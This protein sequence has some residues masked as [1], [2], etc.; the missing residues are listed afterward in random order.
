MNRRNL[1]VHNGSLEN[2]GRVLRS[3]DLLSAVYSSDD[4]IVVCKS[5]KG[6][7]GSFTVCEVDS[8]LCNIPLIGNFIWSLFAAVA[9]RGRYN[10]VYIHDYLSLIFMIFIGVFVKAKVKIYDAHE[11]ILKDESG[12]SNYKGYWRNLE[13]RY[14]EDFNCVICANAERALYVEDYY[15]LKVIPIVIP[16]FLEAFV[17]NTTAPHVSV[18]PVF[19]YQGAL[20][21]DRELHRFFD[22][23]AKLDFEFKLKII[24]AGP[25]EFYLQ[26]Y[27]E[28]LGIAAS[29]EWV[30]RVSRSVLYDMLVQADFGVIYY[31]HKGLN[32]RMCA[33]N[34]IFEYA[35]M[36]LP[37]ITSSQ[38]SLF[39]VVTKNKLGVVIG[40]SEE[41]GFKELDCVINDYEYFS[42]KSL[43]FARVNSWSLRRPVLIDELKKHIS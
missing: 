16:N 10:T 43:D 11:I 37:V 19:V 24:G 39:N 17:E 9:V 5:G 35:A 28:K 26:R 8:L 33:P 27:A 22:F 14:I 13:K 3:L 41:V 1:V 20:T 6:Y 25:E 15:G 40:R 30:G 32:T 4:N 29:V 18:P 31:D 21:K 23:I 38:Q 7:S 42:K 36:G 34:K 12:Y 2:D